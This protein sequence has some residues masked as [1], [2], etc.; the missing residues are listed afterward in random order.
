MVGL[1]V[2]L[3]DSESYAIMIIETVIFMIVNT[4]TIVGFCICL[5]TSIGIHK[6]NSR[7]LVLLKTLIE[8]SNQ[9]SHHYLYKPMICED[10]YLTPTIF[11]FPIGS[12][13]ESKAI[14]M[15]QKLYLGT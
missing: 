14:N 8:Y 6:S 5:C 3:S 4:I 15:T 7:N 12:Y 2:G 13:M 11:K 1:T 9:M 10:H